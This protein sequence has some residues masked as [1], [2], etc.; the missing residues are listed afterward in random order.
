MASL[1]EDLVRGKV[2]NAER[3]R[4]MIEILLGTQTG[5]ERIERD[6]RQA[7][8]SLTR[9]GHNTSAS[10]TLGSSTCRPIVRSCSW[11]R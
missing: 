1:L 10:G 11:S 8:R 5:E 6:C 3:S 7:R 2:I 4:Q 9:P